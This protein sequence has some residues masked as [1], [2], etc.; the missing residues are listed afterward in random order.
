MGGVERPTCKA[1]CGSLARAHISCVAKATRAT[2]SSPRD[3]DS[4]GE[5]RDFFHS[6]ST[7]HLGSTGSLPRC[8]RK[9]SSLELEQNHSRVVF[10]VKVGIQLDRRRWASPSLTH[11]LSRSGNT[12]V[13][14][15]G[16][17]MSGTAPRGT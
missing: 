17:L 14:G 11:S 8:H 6:H 15:L 7:E 13:T 4:D 10:T 3:S 1:R 12:A 9:Q 2:L 16:R 5:S